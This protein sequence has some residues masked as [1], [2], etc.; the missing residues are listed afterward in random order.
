M[1]KRLLIVGL[2]LFGAACVAI[3]PEPPAAS[4]SEESSLSVA[5]SEEPTDCPGGYLEMLPGQSA[6]DPIDEDIPAHIDIVGVESGLD[7]EDLTVVFYLRD[8]PEEMEFNRIGVEDINVEY[9]WTVE[10][11]VE[12]SEE[13]ESE[14]IEYTFGAFYSASRVLADTPPAT[15]LFNEAVQTMLWKLVRDHALIPDLELRQELEEDVTIM[16]NLPVYVRKIVSLE[17]DTLTLISEI[18]GIT[19][20]SI[21]TFSTFDILLGQDGV[22]CLPN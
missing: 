21:L 20:E 13:T 3:P 8:I 5:A 17:D 19:S 9:M 16:L 6:K 10:I 15:R 7:G 18:P 4:A 2:A 22:S 1:F 12:K 11:F 14:Q